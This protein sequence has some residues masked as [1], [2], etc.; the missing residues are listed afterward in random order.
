VLGWSIVLVAYFLTVA[1]CYVVHIAVSVTW[2]A[3]ESLAFI[4]LAAVVVEQY[5]V[6][7]DGK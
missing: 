2:E 7:H 3:E 6:D 4:R 5:V 1:A